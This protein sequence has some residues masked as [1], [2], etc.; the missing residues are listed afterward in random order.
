MIKHRGSLFQRVTTL[1]L[2]IRSRGNREKGKK[3]PSKLHQGGERDGGKG[4]SL[5]N[6]KELNK[7]LL[8]KAIS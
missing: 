6:R 4:G 8:K 7:N 2:G 3:G 1:V 5:I